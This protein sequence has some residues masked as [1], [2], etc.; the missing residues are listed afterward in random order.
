VTLRAEWQGTAISDNDR[1]IHGRQGRMFA[2]KD[3]KTFKE[4]MANELW[5]AVC[6]TGWDPIESRD[7]LL[8]RVY[9]RLQVDLPPRMDTSAIIKAAGDAVQ[10]SRV[11]HNDNQI[12]HWEVERVGR[13][14]RGQSRIIFEIGELGLSEQ[15]QGRVIDEMAASIRERSSGMGS[16][17]DGLD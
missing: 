7:F 4:D 16:G 17:R 10:L 12:D 9:I 8:G 13:S 15:V 6:A 11:I 1:L 5:R 2:S 14:P 3:Y